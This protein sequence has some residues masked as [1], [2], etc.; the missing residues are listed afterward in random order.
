MDFNVEQITE[1]MTVR[2]VLD[3]LAGGET[4]LAVIIYG[5]LTKF[6]IDPHYGASP[7]VRACGRCDR[8]LTKEML[9]C[10]NSECVTQ[11]ANVVDRFNV[12]TWITDHTGTLKCR[13]ND[14]YATTMLKYNATMF[15]QLP[16]AQIDQINKKYSFQR[17][18][19]KVIVKQKESVKYTAT[20]ADIS[21]QNLTDIVVNLRTY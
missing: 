15:K 21:S 7:I 11:Q 17:F 3:R 8:Y 16:E 6:E 1:V 9:Q 4:R 20:I 13:I 18:A 5:V 10:S 12:L 19:V 2:K 14:D